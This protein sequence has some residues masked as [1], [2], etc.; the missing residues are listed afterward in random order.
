MCAQG[1][2]TPCPLYAGIDPPVDRETPVKILPCPKLRLLVVKIPNYQS[3]NFAC[4]GD[5]LLLKCLYFMITKSRV[6]VRF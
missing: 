3:L 6:E 2:Y 5:G 1:V 4:D